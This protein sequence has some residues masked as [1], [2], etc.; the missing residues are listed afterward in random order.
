MPGYRYHTDL[1]S[2]NFV[3]N[4]VKRENG[5]YV[6]SQMERFWEKSKLRSEKLFEARSKCTLIFQN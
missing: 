6:L 4:A 1:F 3:K 2:S 5:F